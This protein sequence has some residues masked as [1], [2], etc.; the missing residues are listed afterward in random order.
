MY[1]GW[2]PEKYTESGLPATDAETLQGIKNMPLASL[3]VQYADLQKLL[4]TYINAFLDSTTDDDPY[5]R[6]SF[7]QMNTLTMRLS[8][9]KPNMQNI[10]P[11][12][13]SAFTAPP[14]YVVAVAD[15]DAI[16]V[17]VLAY[18]LWVLF[19][20]DRMAKSLIA[21]IS[22]HDT[23]T[24]QWFLIN[25][26]DF[27]SEEL[28]NSE[29]E[30]NKWRLKAKTTLFGVIYG[31][32]AFGLSDKLGVSLSEAEDILAMVEDKMPSIKDYMSLV[33]RTAKLKDRNNKWMSLH[34]GE[35]ANKGWFYT[36]LG[37]RVY[38]PGLSE[39]SKYSRSRAERQVK[40][41]S[42]Q[43]PAG[44]INKVLHRQVFDYVKRNGLG[45]T[46]WAV[47]DEVG[48]YLRRY[49]ATEEVRKKMSW[50]FSSVDLLKC[51]EKYVPIKGEFN[52]GTNWKEAK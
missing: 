48:F 36:L 25:K 4:S 42:I 33:I 1:R 28:A 46:C 8:S 31:Q 17:C 41:A 18:Y 12:V 52:Y 22:P 50:L 10:D 34:T 27:T 20:D 47:H 16:E 26:S 35:R 13:K 3:L 5:I 19:D 43:T 51:E 24:E 29:S 14:G 30:W 45:R 37:H 9:S 49:V 32:T 39:K 2:R 7:N 21:G 11:R 40:N 44:A 15:L 23:N 6:S 38:K